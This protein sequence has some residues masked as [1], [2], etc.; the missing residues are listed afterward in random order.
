MTSSAPHIPE[1]STSPS[2]DR[3]TAFD[4]EQ[5]RAL[6]KT[7]P[8]PS[9]VPTLEAQAQQLWQ[10]F[11]SLPSDLA[12]DLLLEVLYFKVLSEH[13]PELLG[14]VYAPTVG[15]AIGTVHRGRAEQDGGAFTRDAID[16][17]AASTERPLIFP[18]S[19]PTETIEAIPPGVLNWFNGK[20]L[21]ATGI[22]VDPVQHNR[23]TYEIGQAN[24][25]LAV[26][27]GLGVIVAGAQRV[28]KAMLDAAAKAVAHEADVGT[29]GAA[30]LANVKNLRA[31]LA[32]VA[33]AVY[34]AAHADG[35]ATKKPHNVVQ[36]IADT[37]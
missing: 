29:T 34:G 22:P 37:M 21:V 33:E 2:V 7:A 35:V 13:L 31:L 23:T 24:N 14:V 15:A 17:M 28:T 36:A 20:A 3:E 9:A 1:A 11:Q 18:I 6:G 30:L 8:L 32:V 12:R 10:Q 26:G 25:F 4:A 5:R 19:N 27:L 16:A